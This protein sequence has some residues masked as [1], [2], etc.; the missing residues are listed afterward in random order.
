M[1]WG[2]LRFLKVCQHAR[3][4]D[5]FSYS[6]VCS[7]MRVSTWIVGPPSSWVDTLK[8]PSP[9]Q[10]ILQTPLSFPYCDFSV[11][12]VPGFFCCCLRLCGASRRCFRWV[13]GRRCLCVFSRL[14]RHLVGFA[15]WGKE[16]GRGCRFFI[17]HS[18]GWY[19]VFER[20]EF[21]VGG[22]ILSWPGCNLGVDLSWCYS[23]HDVTTPKV[24][25]SSGDPTPKWP[26]FR[27][28]HLT[29]L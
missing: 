7:S 2:W 5:R 12:V 9:S 6:N 26:R 11:F 8:S 17:Y 21:F 24:A 15:I 1:S 27:N 4:Y 13:A 19:F 23:R 3:P 10:K 28:Q 22:G 29:L 25:I 14:S 16:G 18:I 20:F